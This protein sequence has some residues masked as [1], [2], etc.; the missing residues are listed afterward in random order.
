M[1][2]LHNIG[3]KGMKNDFQTRV[4]LF[5]KLEMPLK[6]FGNISRK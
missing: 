2:P 6:P 4:V 3:M 5:G 1:M